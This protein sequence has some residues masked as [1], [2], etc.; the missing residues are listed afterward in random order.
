MGMAEN[1]GDG[2]QPRP[3]F[4]NLPNAV[5]ANHVY[6]TGSCD[7]LRAVLFGQFVC[8]SVFTETHS[9]NRL[10]QSFFTIGCTVKPELVFSIQRL[11]T[12]I[13]EEILCEYSNHMVHSPCSD[14]LCTLR[15]SHC[16]VKEGVAMNTGVTIL[17]NSLMAFSV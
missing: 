17:R 16:A 4:P 8:S 1:I 3:G 5:L 11:Y 12:Q 6:K 15:V 2:L 9:R 13:A 7:Q 10:F 14:W